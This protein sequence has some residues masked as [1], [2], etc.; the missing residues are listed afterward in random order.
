MGRNIHV[1]P[2]P[3]GW[4]VREGSRRSGTFQTKSEALTAGRKLAA[5][6]RSQHIVH[7]R[8]GRIEEKDTFGA[9]PFPSRRKS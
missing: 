2:S 9:D 3:D 1:E 8:S 5:K 7:G 6:N 4:A